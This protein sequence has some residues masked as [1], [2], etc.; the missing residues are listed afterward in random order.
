MRVLSPRMLP[1]DRSLLGS[2]ASTAIRC[3]SPVRCFPKLSMNVLFPAPGTP[4]MP[5]RTLLPDD[6]R[7][8]RMTSCAIVWCSAFAL[9]TNV[10]A[11]LSMFM[12]PRRIP[13]T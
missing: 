10:I 3:P 12:S 2:I 5:M 11:W 4:V 6:G 7:H 8:L 13:S 1:F 9:S